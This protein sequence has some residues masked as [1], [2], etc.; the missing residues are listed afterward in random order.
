MKILKFTVPAPSSSKN[1]RQLFVNAKGKPG[2]LPSKRAKASKRQIQAAA[3]T[4]IDQL[5][6]E[7]SRSSL[8]GADDDIRVDMEFN[9]ETQEFEVS[10]MRYGPKPKRGNTGRGRDLD[11]MT[12]TVLDALQGVVYADDKQV[13]YLQ[14]DRVYE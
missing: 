9:A 3:L 1:S 4:A 8:F 13:A 12:S 5:E 7:L 14:V 10:V 6:G 2:S 11:N